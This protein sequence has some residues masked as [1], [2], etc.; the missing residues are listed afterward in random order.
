V[1]QLGINGEPDITFGKGAFVS[2]TA[3]DTIK[4]DVDYYTI[5]SQDG[6]IEFEVT[7]HD[8]TFSRVDKVSVS[9]VLR[10]VPDLPGDD[11]EIEVELFVFNEDDPVHGFDGYDTK[12]DKIIEV[13]PAEVDRVLEHQLGRTDL[14]YVNSLSPPLV[15]VKIRVKADDDGD[16][17]QIQVDQIRFIPTTTDTQQQTVLP[18]TTDYTDPGIRNP[19]MAEIKPGEGFLVR[20]D[21]LK[22]GMMNV[23]WAFENPLPTRRF[24]DDGDND[25][26]SGTEHDGNDWIGIL[27]FRGVVVDEDDDDDNDGDRVSV[28]PPGGIT[29]LPEIDDDVDFH[30]DDLDPDDDDID[31]NDDGNVLVTSAH[32]HHGASFVR[33]GFFDVESGVYT[34][35]YFNNFDNSDDFGQGDFAIITTSPFTPNGEDTGTW[36][37][38]SIFKDYVIL[39][40]SDKLSLKAVVRQ[41]PGPIASSEFPWATNQIAWSK[42]L[43]LIQSWGE[44]IDVVALVVDADGDGIQDEVDTQPTVASR[45]FTDV[46]R[47]GVTSGSILDRGGIEVNVRDLN[48]PVGGVLIWATGQGGARATVTAC[49]ERILLSIG[50]VVKKACTASMVLEVVRGPIEIPLSRDF[51]AAVPS[52]ATVIVT[53]ITPTITSIQNLPD[54]EASLIIEGE[55]I[56]LTVEAGAS[57]TVQEGGSPSLPSPTSTPTPTPVPPAPTPTATP[58]P[59]PTPTPAPLPT[60]TP[61]P[62]P[63]PTPTPLPPTPTP[64]AT[65]TPVPATPL[66]VPT[67]TAEPSPTAVPTPEPTA[68]PEPTPTPM[69]APAPTPVTPTPTPTPTPEP[70]PTPAP[71][72]TPTPTPEPAA[73][74]GPTPIPPEPTRTPTPVPPTPTP[75]P[76]TPTP[77][78]PTPTPT[79]TPPPNAAPS[80][81]AG[82]DQTVTATSSSGASVTLDGSGSSDPDGDSLTYS[83]SS[84]SFAT[85]TGQT[86]T[87]VLSEGAHTITLTLSDGTDTAIDTVVITVANAAPVANAGPDQTVTATS[88]SGASV[89]LDGSGSS[90]PDGDSLTYSWSGPSFATVAGQTV[91]VVLA[92]GS[93][94]ITLTVSDGTA[95]SSDSL[96]LLVLNAAPVAN[97]G[98]DQ[99]VTATSSS[100]ASVTLDGSGS[101]DPDGDALT[102]SWSGTFGSATGPTPT[103]LLAQGSHIIALSVSDGTASSS[104]TVTIAVANAAPVANA[105]ADQTVTATS[106]SGASVTLDG[107]GSS[108]PDGDSLTY[109]WSSPSFATITG[110]TATVVLAEGTHTVTLTL[111]DG[112]DTDTDTVV[113]TVNNAV[114]IANAGPDQTV[115]ATSSSGAS[116]TLDGSGSSDPDGDALTYSW[117]SP[118]FATVAGQTVTV[119]L[120][121]GSHTITL[122]V[123]DGTASNSDTVTITVESVLIATE[124]WESGGLSGGTGWLGSWLAFGGND[125]QVTSGNQPFEGTSHLRL[126]GKNGF[127]MRD[128]NL[129]GQTGVHLTFYAKVESFEGS[130]SALVRVFSDGN[131]TTVKTWTSADSDGVYKLVDIDLSGF[132][133]TSQ[134]FIAFQGE[135]SSFADRLLIDNIEVK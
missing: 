66:P 35:V 119:V 113:I 50:D 78:P 13:E 109:S 106:Q 59:L 53:K 11:D 130:D 71:T 31:D 77:V 88:S 129:S 83:W 69:P 117:S 3:A 10:K 21:G 63:T 81:N 82:A 115:T 38:G 40:K 34:I 61:A 104:D 22:P 89:T 118:S 94:T 101:S 105:G 98:P 68:T 110:Q 112:T 19:A 70:T 15:T 32:V 6:V 97:A 72:A 102:Y 54:S 133:M 103:I 95:S 132:T 58:T 93:H 120:A 14:E 84:P 12:P 17:F 107:S 57:V 96:T 121:E 92:E 64:L 73:L 1:D 46:P 80:A 111:S 5:D 28:I 37:Y 43:V 99:T 85:I 56:Q 52:G 75:V 76:P 48:D 122:T 108:D 114:P 44:P 62:T 65:S 127:V 100:G 60:P 131:W 24:L 9:L 42:N 135:M 7:S 39:A 128:V 33:T 116:V 134:V 86:V 16:P 8:F 45:D 26:G 124:N 23:T 47:G 29:D 27:V 79:P 123:S 2:G 91:T 74:P 125:A 4:D 90:D 25:A 126:R 67:P 30:R 41:V 55:D 20:L 18:A 49:G 87:V 36:I 51:E